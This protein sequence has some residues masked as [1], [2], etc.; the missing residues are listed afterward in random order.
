[1]GVKPMSDDLQKY[2]KKRQ[3]SPDFREAWEA[4]KLEYEVARQLIQLRK[5]SGLTQEQLAA[6]VHTK[7]SEIS[8]IENGDQNISLDKLRKIAQAMGAEVQVQIKPAKP[9]SQVF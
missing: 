4:S 2:L 7:Q 6:K 9:E 8:R 1:M 5:K 3:E